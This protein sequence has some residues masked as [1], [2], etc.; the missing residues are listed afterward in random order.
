MSGSGAIRA[1]LGTILLVRPAGVLLLTGTDPDGVV[2]ALARLLGGRYLAQG[3]LDLAVPHD[4]RID[5]AVELIHAASMLSLARH[6]RQH[7]RPA[8][9]SAGVALALG[10]GDLARRPR[11]EPAPHITDPR[12][13]GDTR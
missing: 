13:D 4:R 9:L 1:A 5:A 10:A 8:L 3:A 11:T 12:Q 6:R 2:V 7:V